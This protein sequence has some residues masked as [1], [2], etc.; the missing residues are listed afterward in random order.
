M[1]MKNLLLIVTVVFI[2]ANLLGCESIVRKFTRKTK[3][4]E[5][6]KEEM[7]LVPEEYKGQQ[8][9][10]EELYRKRLMYWESWQD[11]VISSLLDN[12]SYKK[13]VSCIN[14]AVKH[15]KEMQ[16]M[17]VGAKRE[18]F[19]TYVKRMLELQVAITEDSNGHYLS[20][21]RSTAEHLK[22]EILRHFSYGDIK[23]SLA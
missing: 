18:K 13:R 5:K 14:Y 11:E 22:I 15:I 7:V 6:H 2:I 21:N 1:R 8:M 4:S 17:L 12:A 9:S 19:D 10:K 20:R 16:G 3:D 23:D